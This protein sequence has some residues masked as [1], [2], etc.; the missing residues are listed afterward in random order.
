MTVNVLKKCS[1]AIAFPCLLASMLSACGGEASDSPTTAA[2]SNG[3]SSSVSSAPSAANSPATN[4]SPSISG[5][6]VTNVLTG[7]AYSFAPTAK[8]PNGDTLAFS[9]TGTLPPGLNF[10][11]ATGLLSGTPSAAGAYGG[12]VISVTDGK[13]GT[14]KL[15]AFTIT[16]ASGANSAVL[17]WAAPTSN[18]DG[19]PLTDLEGYKVYYGTSSTSLNRTVS[20]ASGTTKTTIPDLTAGVTYYFA[21]ASISVGDGEGSKSDVVSGTI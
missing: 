16:V 1:I 12:I 6:P 14:A 8:D 21:I 3:S 18:T 15:P 9:R 17:S 13:G 7:K 20:I 19:S 5:T 4:K 2:V 11:T 10:N